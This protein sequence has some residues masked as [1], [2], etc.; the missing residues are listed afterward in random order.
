MTEPSSIAG[1]SLIEL[2]DFYRAE[3]FDHFLPFME[4]HL[5]DHEYGG[6]MCHADRDGTLLSTEKVTWYMA[7]GVWVYSFLYSNFGHDR[8]FLDV[9]RAALDLLLKIE[10]AEPGAQWPKRFSREGAALTPPD[11]EVY[12]N[13]F[14]AEGL[15]AYSAAT[16]E[17]RWL[18]KAKEILHQCLRFYDSPDYA[19]EIGQTYL[20]P[21][22]LPFPGARVLGVSMISL[23]LASQMLELGP[24]AD[25]QAISDRSL[26]ALLHRHLHPEFGLLNELLAHDFSRDNEFSQLV[27]IGHAIE[28]MW[29]V[30]DEALRRNDAVLWNRAAGLFRRHVDVA[31][32]DV[33]DGVFRN[34]RDVERNV[35]DVDKVL[36]EQ[37]EVSIG[38]L[39]LVERAGDAWAA[40][41]FA[42]MFRYV[43]DRFRLERHGLPLYMFTADRKVTFTAHSDR[44]ENYHLPRYLM[45]NLLSIERM[46][47]RQS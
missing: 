18:V 12:G 31:W 8:K 34:I 15:T 5:V 36:W 41:R 3:L 39:L 33:Y 10:P 6:F 47:V 9:A 23:R 37:L 20:G 35:W 19:P 42:R 43:N 25:I 22:A 2:R 11:T 24:D 28:A 40:E 45:L 21:S 29:M 7:R 13:L 17:D 27:Y 38:C 46:L 4:R 44:I 14:I 32:D 30:M 26:D 1:L 16:G